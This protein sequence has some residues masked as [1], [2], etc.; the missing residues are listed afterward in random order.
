MFAACVQ[1]FIKNPKWVEGSSL[2]STGREMVKENSGTAQQDVGSQGLCPEVP[3]WGFG[4]EPQ[5]KRKPGN[6]SI[7]NKQG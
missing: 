2:S 1:L 4:D 3:E 7:R 6:G 5:K